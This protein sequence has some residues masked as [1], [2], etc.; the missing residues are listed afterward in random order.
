[1]HNPNSQSLFPIV[2]SVFTSLKTNPN[3][4]TLFADTKLVNSKRQ[5]NNLKSILTSARLKLGEATFKVSKCNDK[6]CDL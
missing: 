1:M 5:H 4:Q 3:T 2:S 6:K